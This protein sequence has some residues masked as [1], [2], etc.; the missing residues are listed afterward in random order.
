[1][2][3]HTTVKCTWL[4]TLHSTRSV[5]YLVLH[6]LRTMKWI[7]QTNTSATDWALPSKTT[8]L[9]MEFTCRF[10]TALPWCCVHVTV[11]GNTVIFR[12]SEK[13]NC[14]I[15]QYCIWTVQS[16]NVTTVIMTLLTIL[17]IYVTDD[18]IDKFV[19]SY[20]WFCC[21]HNVHDRCH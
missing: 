17:N 5:K 13:I 2:T 9:L 7:V 16:L 8:M 20:T 18:Y 21:S 10:S 3:S 4:Q 11:R 1:M 15:Q 14:L 12:T 6:K 19:F